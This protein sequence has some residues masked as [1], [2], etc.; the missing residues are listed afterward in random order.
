MIAWLKENELGNWKSAGLRITTTIDMRV[1]KAMEAELNRTVAG[2]TMS[3]QKENMIGAGVAIEPTTGRVLAYYGG[4]NNGN[5]TDWAGNDQPHPPASSFKIY[6]LAAAIADGIS[7]Q[8]HWNSRELKKANG[9]PVDL[10]N[11]S[12]ESDP[13][14]DQSAPSNR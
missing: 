1:Q 12:R 2:S 3:K 11:A 7:I 6:T 9:D 13:G 14:C 4:S 5:E 8:S 10:T